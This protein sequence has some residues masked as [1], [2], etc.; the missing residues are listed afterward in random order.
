EGPIPGAIGP[1]GAEKTTL[2]QLITG[3]LRPAS[4]QV[5][6][7]GEDVTG[8]RPW[9]IAHDGVARTFQIVRPFRGLTDRENVA[10]GA[11]HGNERDLTVRDSLATADEL[12]ELVGIA[13]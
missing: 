4:G 13:K 7:D 1:N 10:I 8:S 11:M 9:V 3:L 5:Q 12:L 6:I 2:V